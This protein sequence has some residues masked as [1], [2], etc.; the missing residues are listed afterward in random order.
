MATTRLI[1]IHISKGK[2]AGGS[3]AARLDYAS[4]PEK[5]EDGQ[6]VTSFACDP[7]TAANEFELMRRTYL[8]IT[9]R[10]RDGE[11][12]A[13]QLR[14]SFKPGEVTPEEANQ[15]GRELAGRFLKGN[16]AY[17]VATHTD[18]AHIHNHIIFCATTLDCQH[19]F[20]NFLGSGKALA[21]L[22]DQICMEHKLYVVINPRMHDTNYDRWQG[23]QAK[24]SIRDQLRLAIDD[25]LKT[26]P[27]SF[28]A[29]LN[30][31]EGN[32]WQVKRGKQPSF[33][34]PDG[35]RFIRM[36]SLGES[37]TEKSIREVLDGLRVHNPHKTRRMKNQVSLLI[38]IQA[39]MQEGKGKG[40]ENWAKVFNVK[41]M[42]SSMAYLSSHNIRSY[43]ELAAKV[44]AAVQGND[45]LLSEVKAAEAR[46]KEIAATKKSIHDYLKT[47]DVYAEWKKSGYD[48]TFYAAHEQEIIIHKAAKK[49]FDAIPGKIPTIKALSAEYND[50]LAQKQKAYALYRESRSEMRE[51]LT[52]KA[53]IDMV[54]NRHPASRGARDREISR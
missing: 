18:K 37:Y 2:S 35:K 41:Q 51:L 31:L 24:L 7:M 46:L 43:E 22:S 45:N 16:H 40:Y 50:V 34:G 39:K 36:D 38:D 6:L 27:E 5:T 17:I 20:R 25:A 11:V 21:R 8:N 13:Y 44:E 47:K 23:D 29:L 53:N 1:T 30:T 49:A 9:G 4:N 28:D 54:T 15:I 32:G 52:V 33:C 10:H 26:K 3:F 12:I 42:A 48:K 14:Q 19:K